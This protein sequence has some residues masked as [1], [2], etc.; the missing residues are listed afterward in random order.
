M[1]PLRRVPACRAF[2]IILSHL[3]VR[4]C[5]LLAVRSLSVGPQ[6]SGIGT[7]FSQIAQM[8]K[9]RSAFASHS[10]MWHLALAHSRTR[11]SRLQPARDENSDVLSPHRRH[12][13][14][15]VL[16]T[17]SYDQH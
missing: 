9:S 5:S 10:G 7:V 3:R 14:Y 15:G 13:T 4:A 2:P 12:A 17:V 8:D 16:K 11:C 1:Y 6:Y